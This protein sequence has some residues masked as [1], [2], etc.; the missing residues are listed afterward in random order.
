MPVKKLPL[1]LVRSIVAY[2]IT[3]TQA[4]QL[5]QVLRQGVGLLLAILLAK[6]ALTPAG[7]GRYEQV[8]FLTYA[9][10]FFWSVGLIQGLLA[11]YPRLSGLVRPALLWGASLL[12]HGVALLL[13]GAL[14]AAPGPIIWFFAGQNQPVGLALLAIFFFF[15]LPST[16]NEYYL[17]LAQRP[18]PIV[19]YGLVTQLGQLLVVL[20]AVWIWGEVTAAIAALTLVAGGKWL[21]HWR[22]MAQ[23]GS[24]CW[25]GRLVRRW[26]QQSW[27]LLA[28]ALLGGLIL[29][30]N[31]WLVNYWAQGD[32]TRFALFRYGSREF[33]LA[34]ALVEGLNVAMIPAVAR[35]RAA[36]LEK[37]RR[38]S[39]R[40]QHQLFPLTLGLLLS[41]QW[42]FPAVFSPEFS[43]AIPVFNT[44]LLLLSSRLIFSR[45]VMTGAGWQVPGLWIAGIEIALLVPLGWLGLQ[46]GGLVGLALANAGVYLV[47]KL[48][49]V[50]YLVRQGISWGTYCDWRWWLGYSAVLLAAWYAWM[51]WQGGWG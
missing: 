46:W 42:W 24:W 48:L 19:G 21:W 6:S 23:L 50:A 33:P 13:V 43:G 32:P 29:V 22:L 27:P 36:G 9:L 7:V 37:I 45:T 47:E 25:E 30:V 10:S 28:Y 51:K 38:Q 5:L 20:G 12:F 17:L 15:H 40:L 26:V 49:Q 41:S 2:P 16:L 34:V 1:N 14:V 8:V 39:T 44:F 31:Q 18:W 3:V 11:Y 4:M 35:D